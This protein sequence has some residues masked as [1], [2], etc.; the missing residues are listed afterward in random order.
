M[1]SVISGSSYHT[2][3]CS[4]VYFSGKFGLMSYFLLRNGV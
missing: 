3:V 4:T 1:I 2:G